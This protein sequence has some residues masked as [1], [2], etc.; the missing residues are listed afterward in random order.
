VKIIKTGL[1]P[2]YEQYS[3]NENRLT[4][5]LLHTIGSSKWLFSRFLIKIVG[6]PALPRNALYEIST[7]KAPFA[8]GDN[9]PEQIESIPDAWI[10]DGTSSLGIAIEV[11]D[12]KN[13]IRL[14]QLRKHANRIKSYSH[15]YLLV[16][17]PDREWPDQIGEFERK[18]GKKLKIIWHSWQEVYRWLKDLANTP[19]LK[20]S[21]E[22]FLIV[23]IQ[24]YL[25]RRSEVLGFEG[26][27]FPGGFDVAVAKNI[28]NAMME[29]LEPSVR[30]LYRDL[31]DRRPAITTFSK[32]GVWDCFGIRGIKFTEDLHCPKILDKEESQDDVPK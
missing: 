25:E 11:K 6:L 28:L 21:M 26:I 19:S 10:V 2:L 14:D 5:A 7:Q 27:K 13:S 32:W 18:E 30:M 24:E 1:H 4:H 17:T 20:K 23:S 31:G 3:N 12:K 8:E 22:E 15:Q 16:I 9:D 29:E